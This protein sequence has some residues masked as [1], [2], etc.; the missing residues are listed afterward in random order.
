MVRMFKVG[1]I[2]V[3]KGYVCRVAEVKRKFSEG[4]GYM[5]IKDGQEF[6]PTVT[7]IP[8]Y[9]PDGEPVKKA[10]VRTASS[11]AVFSAKE[12]AAD[13]EREILR[14]K[15]RLELLKALSSS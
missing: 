2:V 13:I 5:G 10:G 8:L 14:K 7:M 3:H 15:K 12:E 6:N 1:D 9:G 4:L 11:G